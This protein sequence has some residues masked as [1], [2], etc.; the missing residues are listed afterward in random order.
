MKWT[1]KIELLHLIELFVNLLNLL[2]IRK[3]LAHDRAVRQGK[4]LGILED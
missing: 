1:G 3:Q 4:Q 2:Q